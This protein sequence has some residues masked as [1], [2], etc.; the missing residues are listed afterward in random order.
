MTDYGIILA[1]GG[2]RRM[3]QPKQL[4]ELDGTTLVQ[5]A[6]QTVR[7]AGAQPLVVRGSKATEIAERLEADHVVNAEWQRGMGSS[8]ACGIAALPDEAER[9]LVLTVDQPDVDADLLGSLLDT[10][11]APT[12]AAATLYPDGVL[13]V[14][15]CFRASLFEALEGCSE[16]T[17]ARELLRS[18]EHRVAEIPAQQRAVDIDTPDDWTTYLARRSGGAT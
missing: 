18:G 13:G 7:Q 6:I 4:L 11:E 9:A 5:R 3:G 8:L 17:G 1:A 12:D 15:A 2:S 16:D 10:C 14:P